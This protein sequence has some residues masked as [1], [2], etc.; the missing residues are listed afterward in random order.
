MRQ[1]PNVR[2]FI[3]RVLSAR[4]MRRCPYLDNGCHKS[5][6]LTGQIRKATMGVPGRVPGNAVDAGSEP[7]SFAPAID[8]M[9][10]EPDFALPMLAQGAA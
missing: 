10:S 5:P 8:L 1:R 9:G 2:R 7:M 3:G 6:R 4:V